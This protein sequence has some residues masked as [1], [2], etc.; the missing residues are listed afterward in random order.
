MNTITTKSG[1]HLVAVP[2]S[3]MPRGVFCVCD[4]CH[5]KRSKFES[6]QKRKPSCVA[7]QRPDGR[8]IYWVKQ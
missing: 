1:V 5:F 6:C 2:S 7:K 8:S 3:K 4:L